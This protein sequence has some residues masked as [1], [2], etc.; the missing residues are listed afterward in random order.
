[1]RSTV[2]ALP[3]SNPIDK[4]KRPEDDV[5]RDLAHY[6]ETL[7]KYLTD[8]GFREG[9]AKLRSGDPE[10]IRQVMASDPRIA[11]A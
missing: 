11:Q 7:A 8:T 3:S 2:N 5:L 10:E 4:L 6:E 1:M 9:L